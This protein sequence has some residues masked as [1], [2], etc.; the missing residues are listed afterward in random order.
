MKIMAICAERNY[1]KTDY[2]LLD[3]DDIFFIG[4]IHQG[5]IKILTFHTKYEKYHPIATL[6]GYRVLL[7]DH[8]FRSRDTVN[9]VN[10]SKIK[11]VVESEADIRVYFEDGSYTTVS[12]AKSALVQNYPKKTIDL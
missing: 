6:E 5:K 1:D 12:R 2:K 11:S 4:F 10:M 9:V 7:E 3:L 8:R